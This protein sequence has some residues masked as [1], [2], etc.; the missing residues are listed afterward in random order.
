MSWK[1]RI[2]HYLWL[3]VFVL[4]GP[5]CAQESQLSGAVA[6]GPGGETRCR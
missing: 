6:A 2:R 3:F 5:V 1:F 4:C